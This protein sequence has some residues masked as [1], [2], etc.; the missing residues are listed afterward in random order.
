M[1]RVF[2]LILLITI[3]QGLKA[4]EGVVMVKAEPKVD[5]LIMLH[6]I[7]NQ[8]YPLVQGYRIQLFKDSGNDALDAAH[9]I[10]DKFSEQ[11]P[12]VNAYLSF[13]EP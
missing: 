2:V 6:V 4:Q 1:K 3:L 7:H 13:R 8:T 5:S 9:E 12:G 10:M 11:F